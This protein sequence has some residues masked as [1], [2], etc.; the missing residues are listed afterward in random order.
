MREASSK[1]GLCLYG[2]LDLTVGT[3]SALTLLS[4]LVLVRALELF[5]LISTAAS[6]QLFEEHPVNSTSWS[7]H[8]AVLL[9]FQ[10]I[11]DEERRHRATVLVDVVAS[12]SQTFMRNVDR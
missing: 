8:S 2:I 12:K 1:V 6:P 10:P 7:I 4:V 5:T 11:L 9:T 3:S